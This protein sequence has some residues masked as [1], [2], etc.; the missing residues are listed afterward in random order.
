MNNGQCTREASKAGA[1]QTV[2]KPRGIGGVGLVERVRG[3]EARDVHRL[4]G[5]HE[6]VGGGLGR[7]RHDVEL[8]RVE[9]VHVAQVVP[10]LS[11][12]AVTRGTRDM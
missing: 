6:H 11:Q 10:H 7:G 5:A 9:P 2:Y 3:G 8:A 4:G 12:S 1:K